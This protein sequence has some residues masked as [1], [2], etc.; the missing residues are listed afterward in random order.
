MAGTVGA[1]PGRDFSGTVETVE[2]RIDPATRSVTVRAAFPNPERLLRPGMLVSVEL[3]QP[4]R[5]ALLVPEI[6]IVQVGQ[7]SFVWRV[8]ADGSVEQAKVT[9]GSRVGGQAEILDGLAAGD[10]IVVDGTGKLR[11]GARVVDAPAA[12]G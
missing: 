1:W 4:V 10:R 3:Q 11:P 9:L 6:A 12:Q 7:T 5:E 2:S 8:K